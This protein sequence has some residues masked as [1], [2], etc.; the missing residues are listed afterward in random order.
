M[1]QSAKV[2]P[3]LSHTAYG[4]FDRSTLLLHLDQISRQSGLLLA[5]WLSRCILGFPDSAMDGDLTPITELWNIAGLAI[6]LYRYMEI[7]VSTCK[8]ADRN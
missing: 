4:E 8:F 2:E 7:K 1:T 3:E 5:L 6:I